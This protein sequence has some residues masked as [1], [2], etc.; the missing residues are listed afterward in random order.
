MLEN[1]LEKLFL[2]GVRKKGGEAFKFSSPGSNGVPDRV[3][4]FEGQVFFV[5]LKK[6]GQKLRPLQKAMKRKF[7][8]L[9]FFVYVVDSARGVDE[10]V[11]GLR[12]TRLSDSSD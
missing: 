4:L 1:E 9:G 6:P 2:R 10:F 5:E 3:V 8:R 12:S 11:D 7:E